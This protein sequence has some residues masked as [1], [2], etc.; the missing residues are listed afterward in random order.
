MRIISN[1][2]CTYEMKNKIPKQKK[3]TQTRSS[4]FKSSWRCTLLTKIRNTTRDRN[5]KFGINVIMGRRGAHP[6]SSTSSTLA[7]TWRRSL[8]QHASS[9]CSASSTSRHSL[10]CQ[11]EIDC[12]HVVCR[13][14]IDCISNSCMKQ[15]QRFGGCE[16]N[17]FRIFV[18]YLLY[19][20]H[21]YSCK[22]FWGI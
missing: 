5:D 2:W 6:P 15:R 7:L 4:G 19:T 10:M 22:Y 12:T 20:F 8:L 11:D 9:S 3:N 18:L 14:E 1:T 16:L 13:D 17:K 21:T